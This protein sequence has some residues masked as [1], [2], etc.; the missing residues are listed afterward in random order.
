M[1]SP[2]FDNV[3]IGISL[4][5]DDPV[6]AAATNGTTW[7]AAERD[8][9][10]NLAQ[11][12]LWDF[13]YQKL[14]PI[15]SESSYLSR[16]GGFYTGAGRTSSGTSLI[17]VSADLRIVEILSCVRT[18]DSVA[19]RMFGQIETYRKVST[20][21]K[22]KATASQPIGF[23]GYTTV[24]GDLTSVSVFPNSAENQSVAFNLT[25][26]TFPNYLMAN[27]ASP[28]M[29]WNKTFLGALK[30]LGYAH[31]LAHDGNFQAYDAIIQRVFSKY[32]DVPFPSEIK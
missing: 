24:G 13:L 29:V 7:S 6:G 16:F 3:Q 12:T 26:L 8:L 11:E 27:G 19:V 10:V 20:I 5:L 1:A 9:L 32:Q 30:Q 15:Q 23:S 14:K 2:N 22:Y 21:E 18:T 4:L 25:Y 17:D 31:A 28:D